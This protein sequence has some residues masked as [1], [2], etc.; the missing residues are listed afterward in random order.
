MIDINDV[1]VSDNAIVN[2]SEVAD[3]LGVSYTYWSQLVLKGIPPKSVA[4]H[5][6]KPRYTAGQI[7]AFKKEM[8]E[9]GILPL[10]EYGV[11]VATADDNSFVYKQDL[12]KYLRISPTTVDSWIS[13]GKLPEPYRYKGFR[14][15]WK[16]GDI[17]N[18]LLG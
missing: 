5:G 16:V 4:P 9:N 1:G 3:Y 13:E 10:L 17:R 7:R 8:V 14:P 12:A 11:D 6:A 18:K 15:R 2:T